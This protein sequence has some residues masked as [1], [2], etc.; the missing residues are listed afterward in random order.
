MVRLAAFVGVFG[1]VLVSTL[2][3]LAPHRDKIRAIGRFTPE[4]TNGRQREHNE[5]EWIKVDSNNLKD[6]HWDHGVYHKGFS[7]EEKMR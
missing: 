2:H 3:L 7:A 4:A 6:L 5:V 1:L